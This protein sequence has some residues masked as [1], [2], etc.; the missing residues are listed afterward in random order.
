MGGTGRDV[1]WCRAMLESRG[2]LWRTFQGMWERE[3]AGEIER[4][5]R[6]KVE[7][8]T[9]DDED[10]YCAPWT[11][12]GR[13]ECALNAPKIIAVRRLP[14]PPLPTAP[15][16]TSGSTTPPCPP[17]NPKLMHL[18]FIEW[19]IMIPM[20]F[21]LLT[22]STPSARPPSRHPPFPPRIAPHSPPHGAMASPLPFSTTGNTVVKSFLFHSPP[23]HRRTAVDPALPTFL[24]P[25]SGISLS[26]PTKCHISLAGVL[27]PLTAR[28]PTLLSTPTPCCAQHGEG[29]YFFCLFLFPWAHI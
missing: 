11:I 14:P 28:C 13:L 3:R 27:I 21:S 25:T 26:I 29:Y 23:H 7:M 20:F 17:T 12:N 19:E 6:R 1:Q 9:A 5:G 15:R 10:D 4:D 24:P 22:L 8:P 2:G 18:P 16:Q